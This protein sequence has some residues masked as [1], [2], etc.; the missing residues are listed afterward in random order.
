VFSV[1][2]ETDLRIEIG[3]SKTDLYLGGLTS[4]QLWATAALKYKKQG[5]LFRESP[6]HNHNISTL[7]HA[8]PFPHMPGNRLPLSFTAFSYRASLAPLFGSFTVYVT[9]R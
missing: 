3:I 8:I 6:E 5:V 4:L 9:E 2:G 7:P 1:D